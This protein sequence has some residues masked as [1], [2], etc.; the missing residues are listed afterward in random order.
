MLIDDYLD[1]QKQYEKKYGPKTIILMQVGGFFECYAIDNED[2]KTNSENLYFICDFMNIQISRKNKNIQKI[3]RSNP[4]MAGFPLLAIDKF[5]QILLSNKFTVVLIEQVTPPPEPERKITNIYSP[6]TNINYGLSEESSNLVSVYIEGIKVL[7]NHKTNICV[8]LSV[9]DLTTGKSVIY[10]TIADSEDN[11]KAY[12]EIYRFINSHNPKEIIINVKDSPIEKEKL[13]THLEIN[14]KTVHYNDKPDKNIFRL[15]YQKQFLEKVY[16]K[17]GMLSVLEYLDL[18]NKLYGLYSF[19]VLLQFSYEHN[20]RVIQKLDKPEIWESNQYLILTTNSINQ[21]DLV[22][23]NYGNINNKYSSLL[24]IVNNASTAIGKRYLKDKLL[25]PIINTDELNQRYD[26]IEELL[27]KNSEGNYYFREIE[28]NLNKI[29]DIERLHRRMY[30]KQLQP[31][32]FTTLDIAY[33]NILGIMKNEVFSGK[34]KKILLSGEE[35]EKFTNFIKE[36]EDLF[37]MDEINKYHQNNITNSFFRQGK[38]KELDKLQDKL[39][40]SRKFLDDL[41]LKLSQYI[42]KGSEFIKI[43][44]NDKEGYYLQTTKKRGEIMKK[45]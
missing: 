21:L 15:S 1:Y 33:Q 19:L 4:L 22:N 10:E 16:K 29:L 41:S 6:G 42:E 32:D 44:H 36:Y 20:E 18:E 9:I 23:N 25:N 27:N 39:E 5:I 31:A 37:V 3:T 26:F 14:N 24:G 40:N 30:L 13:F 38:I 7:K 11:T 12:D 17:H 45:I 34:L 28:Q 2:E 43:E 35:M 8:G